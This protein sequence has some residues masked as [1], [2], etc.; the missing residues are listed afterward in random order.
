MGNR[1]IRLREF[2]VSQDFLADVPL[3]YR[4]ARGGKP[5]GIHYR[6]RTDECGFILS[7][8]FQSSMKV[9]GL[10]DSV[11]ECRFINE[12]ERACARIEHQLGQTL[13]VL[14]GGYSG[15][16]SLHILNTILNKVIPLSPRGIF[17]MT[18]IM[19]I[20][21]M[22]KA[23]SFWTTDVHL[24]TIT[25]IGNDAGE[26]DI[27]YAPFMDVTH[28]L[29]LTKSIIDVCR[30]FGIPICF[31][32]TP[33]LQIYEGHYITMSYSRAQYGEFT[34]KRTQAN[35]SLN[36]LCIAMSVPFYDVQSAFAERIDLF[37]DDIHM[38]E[39]GTLVLAKSLDE[40][41]FFRLLKSWS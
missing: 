1:A 3:D 36:Q 33:H 20:E 32:S 35:Y 9:V 13:Q 26:P 6:I 18:G 19:D 25:E 22:C 8:D 15:A 40:Q 11:M 30:T 28:R 21:A 14:N 16:T 17:I 23:K 31:I 24:R 29:R 10:G 41:G 2:A 39:E 4:S 5:D 38:N 34:Q 27:N 37:H 12:G 7:G